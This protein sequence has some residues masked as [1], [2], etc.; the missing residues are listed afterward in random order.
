[1][2]IFFLFFCNMFGLLCFVVMFVVIFLFAIDIELEF[3]FDVA[4]HALKNAVN[5]KLNSRT[6][7]VKSGCTY[8]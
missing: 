1:M 5:R 6:I 7:G 8:A 3:D 2:E 4:F